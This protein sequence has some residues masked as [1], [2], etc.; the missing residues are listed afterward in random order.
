[1][2]RPRFTEEESAGIFRLLRDPGSCALGMNILANSEKMIGW[3]HVKS[4]K[5]IV[6]SSGSIVMNNGLRMDVLRRHC[7]K[8]SAIEQKKIY[9]REV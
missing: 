2:S 7:R 3:Y 9:A 8:R 5:K 6:M 4:L 1:M